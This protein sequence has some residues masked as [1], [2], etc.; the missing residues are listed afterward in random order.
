MTSIRPS[1]LAI[2]AITFWITTTAAIAEEVDNPQ[3]SAWSSFNVGTRVTLESKMN[4]G[5]TMSSVRTLKEKADDHVLIEVITTLEKSGKREPSR[6]IPVTIKTKVDQ[7]KV[8]E[9]EHEK[10]E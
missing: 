6:P 4:D 1:V 2:L 8:K 5:M 7:A 3:F 10:V 9:L